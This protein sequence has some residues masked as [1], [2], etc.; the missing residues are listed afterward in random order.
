MCESTEIIPWCLGLIC[1]IRSTLEVYHISFWQG[2]MTRRGTKH[3]GT[4]VSLR[5]VCCLPQN[6]LAKHFMYTQTH[7]TPYPLQ[8]RYLQDC[9]AS[10]GKT[11]SE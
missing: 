4:V 5:L 11:T 9:S 2:K 6:S 3:C 1:S 7:S 10:R 8:C